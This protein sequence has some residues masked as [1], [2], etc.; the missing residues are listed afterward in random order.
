MSTST[1]SSWTSTER[2]GPSAE[3][4]SS[5]VD[6]NYVD[7]TIGFGVK[8]AIVK[9][10]NIQVCGCPPMMI[11]A[12][13]LLFPVG[14]GVTLTM[15]DALYGTNATGPVTWAVDP[16]TIGSFG[17]NPSSGASVIFTRTLAGV[18]PTRF[19]AADAL[20]CMA[21]LLP[22]PPGPTC[23]PSAGPRRLMRGPLHRQH[24]L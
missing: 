19:D 13:N 18:F 22:P 4:G 16:D 7:G 9:F 5:I 12:S 10:D 3:G 21:M 2:K 24:R 20:G 8:D 17:T 15:K 6:K 23:L 11:T 1:T 14:E